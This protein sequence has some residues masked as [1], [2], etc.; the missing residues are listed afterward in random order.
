MLTTSPARGGSCGLRR[1]R[2]VDVPGQRLLRDVVR[3]LDFETVLSFG[4][5]RERDG[6]SGLQLMARGHV[7][8]RRQRL[9]VEILRIRLVEE[10]LTRLARFTRLGFVAGGG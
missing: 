9:R 1:N 8:N 5:R 7:E 6:L 10:L 4:K 3:H 2:E